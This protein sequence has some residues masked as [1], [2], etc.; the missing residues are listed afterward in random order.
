MCRSKKYD[1]CT[2]A[3][4]ILSA[5]SQK[6]SK[7]QKNYCIYSSLFKNEKSC[8]GSLR[9]LGVKKPSLFITPFIPNYLIL[10]IKIFVPI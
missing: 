1:F 4:L 10:S 6:V 3:K 5:S 8:F 2:L 7:N 9:T